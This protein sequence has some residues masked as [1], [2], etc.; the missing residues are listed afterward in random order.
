M[1]IYTCTQFVDFSEPLSY[2]NGTKSTVYTLDA[3]CFTKHDLNLFMES[4]ETIARIKKERLE[5]RQQRR[6]QKIH[7]ARIAQP[8]KQQLEEEDR[9]NI[10][11]IPSAEEAVDEPIM[12]MEAKW[13]P[14]VIS[15]P[16]PISPKK[17]SSEYDEAYG[18]ANQS[19]R[20]SVSSCSGQDSDSTE[21]CFY[22]DTP[23]P[24]R[25]RSQVITTPKN[26]ATHSRIIS[27]MLKR[28]YAKAPSTETMETSLSHDAHQ[29]S[30]KQLLNGTINHQ[31]EKLSALEQN[32]RFLDRA[33]SQLTL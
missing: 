10:S 4:L 29:I 3:T 1:D 30:K 23:P 5:H 9:H 15:D 13:I 22:A 20:P 33:L 24:L 6:M 2:V 18:S 11:P 27:M 28:K 16:L 26:R 21:S 8:E 17:G 14:H 31:H 25:P 32:L 19:P 12:L 7:E